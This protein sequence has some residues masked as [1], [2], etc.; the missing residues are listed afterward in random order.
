MS[1]Q[2]IN[3]DSF[4][5]HL[6]DIASEDWNKKAFPYSWSYAYELFIEEVE[7]F[8]AADVKPVVHG[9][10]CKVSECALQCSVCGDTWSVPNEGMGAFRYRMR[11]CPDCGAYMREEAQ[12]GEK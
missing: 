7:D 1:E 8:T 3:R 4:I 11:Y 12:G 6:K 5:D 2:F 9:K 10:W